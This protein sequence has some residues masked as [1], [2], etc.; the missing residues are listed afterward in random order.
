MQVFKLFMKIL[1]SQRNAAFVYVGIFVAI[2]FVVILPSKKKE[3]KDEFVDR[4]CN[5]AYF[6]YDNSEA[7]KGVIEYLSKIDKEVKIK[8]DSNETIQDELFNRNVS[9]VLVFEKGY[10]AAFANGNAEDKV[11]VYV[12]KNTLTASLFER[13]FDSFTS[14]VK[15]YT[16][17]GFSLAEAFEKATKVS[18][19]E[20]KVEIASESEGDVGIVEVY[21]NYLG[22]IIMSGIIIAVAPVLIAM[23]KDEAKS[24]V[25][26]SAYKFSRYNFEII[27]AL[28]VTG[29]AITIFFNLMA[30]LTMGSE[31]LNTKGLLAFV[32][33]ICYT[34]V[35][36]AITFFI[37]KVTAEAEIVS[38]LSNLIS[39]GMSFLCGVFV[40]M[41][42]LGEGVI[43][44]A[45]FLPTYWY[46][47]AVEEIMAYSTAHIG[48]ICIYMLIEI[49]FGLAIITIAFYTERARRK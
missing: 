13:H 40:P 42:L 5:F 29:F 6:D 10:G 36:I 2:L 35:A 9:A 33:V 48:N 16:E 23:S 21:F 39:L 8:D 41:E 4:Q 19:Q 15:T 3:Q 47:R 31:I 1:K 14:K 28:I 26:V 17:S 49:L 20:I 45:H 25:S 46:I 7:S 38:L 12:I 32:N 34:F 18:E 27:V 22:W 11:S 43:K 44:A 30:A 24:R 37:S